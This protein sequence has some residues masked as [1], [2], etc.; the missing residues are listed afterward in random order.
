MENNCCDF[1]YLF[2]FS[3]FNSM[4][5]KFHFQIIANVTFMHICILEYILFGF[6]FF[7][8]FYYYNL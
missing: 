1:L 8:I 3:I 5:F 7:L 2:M 4:W 6:F